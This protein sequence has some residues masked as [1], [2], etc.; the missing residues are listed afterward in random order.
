MSQ[1]ALAERAGLSRE[2]INLLERGRR[3]SPHRDTVSLLVKALK[4]SADERACLLVAAAQAGQIAVATRVASGPASSLPVRL[5]SFVGREKETAEVQDLLLA[6]RLVTFTGPGGIGKTS[7]AREVAAGLEAAF[8]DGMAL[9]ELAALNDG[10]LVPH[11]IAAIVGVYEQPGEPLLTTLVRALGTSQRLLVLDNCE[12]LVEAC[13]QVVEPLL[14]ACPHLRILVTSREPLRVG[15]EV[16]W[17][18]PT[19]ALP[20]DHAQ[21][22]DAMARSEAV[23]LFVE[24]A[25][26]VRPGFALSADNAGMVAEIC[27]RLDGIPLAIELAAARVSALTPEQI[28]RHLNDRFRLLTTGSRTATPRHQTLRALLDWSHDLLTEPERVVFRRLS[29]F[30]GGWS[31]EAAEA[32]CAGAGIDELEVLDLLT[33]LLAKSLVQVEQQAGEERFRLLETLRQYGQDRLVDSAEVA[34]VRDRHRDW[35]LHLAER[36][37]PELIGPDQVVWLDRLER[38]HDNFRAALGWVVKQGPA[39]LGLR[40]GGALWQLWH[41]PKCSTGRAS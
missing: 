23:R 17:R 31:L 12:H 21:P 18:V 2:A 8:V 7:L 10:E 27:R 3:L 26:A 9:V 6:K 39:E 24:R 33:Q 36:V 14:Q 20:D 16:V 4:L 30:A 22:L 29:V 37:K 1:E 11:A 28:A 38:E 13:A 41:V 40:L 25:T 15:A 34:V 32:V 5:T 35:F 19:L